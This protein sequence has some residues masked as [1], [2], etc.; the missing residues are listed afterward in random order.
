MNNT[1]LTADEISLYD[2]QIRL[3]GMEAQANLRNS[4]ILV[5]NMTGVG[6][7]IVKNLTLGGVGSITI[8]DNSELKE[9]DLNSNFFVTKE[10][11]G[12]N[13]AEASLEKIQAMNPR[14]VVSVDTRNWEDIEKSEIS[15]Y[16]I[17]VATGLNS[18]QN[19]RLNNISR[20]LAIPLISCCTHGLY[21]LIF[22]DLIKCTN[23]IKLERS[24]SRKVGPL[25]PVSKILDIQDIVENDIEMQKILVE[26][27]YRKWDELSGSFLNEKYPSERKKKKKINNV[28]ISLL[29]LLELPEVYLNLDIERISIDGNT[30][31]DKIT[32]VSNRLK[33]PE[34]IQMGEEELDIFRRHAY[35][36]YQPTNS[37][38]GG[39]VSQDIINA[40]VHKEL[41]N[42]NISIL[43]GFNNEMPVYT[44]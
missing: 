23:W 28:L 20:E 31:K 37:I 12:K 9:Q 3:W 32:Q 40:L 16:H 8:C 25:N 21:G 7:E 18:A 26:N 14:V 10:E 38:I 17:I 13:K 42:N 27:K 30:L 1:P 6:V 22:N 33:L 41:P 11:V 43:D 39:V 35:C 4:K 5:I 15:K 34:C 29:G 44:L 24:E 19:S 36:E 2:R